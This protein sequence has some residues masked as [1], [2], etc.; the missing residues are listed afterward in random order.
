[1]GEIKTCDAFCRGCKYVSDVAHEMVCMY[2][3]E[4]G[5][6]RGCHAGTG[7]TRKVHGGKR[8]KQELLF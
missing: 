8:K 1:M 4:T 3:A 7:C 5:E 2:M 6:R